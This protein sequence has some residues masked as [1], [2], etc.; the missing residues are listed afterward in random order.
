M[1]IKFS[2][3]SKLLQ[4]LQCMFPRVSNLLGGIYSKL[5]AVRMATK[6]RSLSL[7]KTI[8]CLR[9]RKHCPRPFDTPMHESIHS[10]SDCLCGKTINEPFGFCNTYV[11]SQEHYWT[12]SHCTKNFQYLKRFT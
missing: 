9:G 1:L 12:K 7:R 10:I 5:L 8:L 2:S 11:R 6:A 4:N 3:C